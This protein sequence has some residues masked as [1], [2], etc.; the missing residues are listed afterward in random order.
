VIRAR[1]EDGFGA[2]LGRAVAGAAILVG[3]V[4]T[5]CGAAALAL[6]GQ[7]PLVLHLYLAAVGALGVWAATALFR[8]ALPPAPSSL[9]RAMPRPPPPPAPLAELESIER[10]V[11][12][13]TATE[14]DFQVRL[15]PL[16]REV[17]A[18]RLWSRHG[19]DMER[20]PAAARRMLGEGTWEALHTQT[21]ADRLQ[22]GRPPAELERL[23]DALEGL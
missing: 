8:A 19:I 4:T 10:Q 9:Q 11:S 20:D 22:P 17:A 13:A 18:Q 2:A 12:F 3:I 16:L 14:L 21:P 6:T 7:R 23:V 1:V 5:G 15:R